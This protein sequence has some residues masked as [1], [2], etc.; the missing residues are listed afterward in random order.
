LQRR[1]RGRLRPGG[2]PALQRDPGRQ[3]GAHRPDRP[4]PARRRAGGSGPLSPPPEPRAGGVAGGGGWADQAAQQKL[5]AQLTRTWWRRIA[6]SERT[7]KSVQ[8]SDPVQDA[9]QAHDL[10]QAD[11]RV[12]ADRLA[13]PARSGQVR[14]QVLTEPISAHHIPV[15]AGHRFTARL[16]A[17]P[18]DHILRRL[19]T[20]V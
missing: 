5:N 20:K 4:G 12:R 1:R 8:P 13:G 9:V 3:P 16:N 18:L 10:G 17:R 19:K 7:W 11:R 14:D 6:R 15:S 2:P